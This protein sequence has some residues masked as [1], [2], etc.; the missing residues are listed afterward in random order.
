MTRTRLSERQLPRYS[1]GEE[2]MN[3][4]TH[5]VGGGMGVIALAFGT[6][7]AALSGDGYA[8]AGAIV[9]GL[10]LMILYTMS[11]IY[12]GLSVNV[13]TA[14]KVFQILD[15]CTIFVLIAGTYTPITICSIREY[16]PVIAW[17]VFG[18]VWGAAALGIVL[19]SID[20]K[21]YSKFSMICYLAM[22]W[23][24]VFT[25]DTIV[26]SMSL[27]GALLVLF[28]GIMYSIGAIF[29]GFTKKCRY[30]HSV[31][32]ILTCIGSAIHIAAVTVYVL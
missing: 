10:S 1:R 9:F 12:H 22:G 8:I 19:N 20:I 26:K 16:D 6:V 17:T 27:D 31:F 4:V 2:I 29:Y 24:I 14:K 30:M 25:G 13:P 32:H 3:M 23:C 18:V 7:K 5:I 28:G 11:S 21:K 15:H